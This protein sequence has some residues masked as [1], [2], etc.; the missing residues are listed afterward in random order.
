MIYTDHSALK[1]LLSNQDAKPR[2]ICWI[3]LLQKFDLEIKN[4]EG[5]ESS[6]DD[7][8][9]RIIQVRDEEEE[10]VPIKEEFSDE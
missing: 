10:S 7:H 3:L 1:Y 9:S 4:K 8:L 5:T 6:I 2:L